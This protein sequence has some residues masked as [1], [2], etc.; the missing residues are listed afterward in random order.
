MNS[1][2]IAASQAVIPPSVCTL[3]PRPTSRRVHLRAASAARLTPPGWIVAIVLIAAC[4]SAGSTAGSSP[5]PIVSPISS[6][7]PSWQA[8]TDPIWRYSINL[9]AGWHEITK[10]EWHW[11]DQAHPALDKYTR[12]FSDEVVANAYS[13]PLDNSGIV[14]TVG[15]VPAKSCSAVDPSQS[16]IPPLDVRIDGT[17]GT[18]TGLEGSAQGQP[19]QSVYVQASLGRYCFYF[20]GF[21]TAH[22]SRDSFLKVFPTILGSFQLGTPA[23]PPF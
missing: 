3:C 7:A 17:A 1:L 19:Y 20:V 9:P 5:S 15:I 21:T 18:V 4:G 23:R 13:L 12:A 6:P 8:Y 2:R 22:A 10:G 16:S 11:V 14:F